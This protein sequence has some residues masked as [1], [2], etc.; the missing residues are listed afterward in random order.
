M[1]L[2]RGD[3]VYYRGEVWTV[4]NEWKAPG[5]AQ[6]LFIQRIHANGKS[7]WAGVGAEVVQKVEQVR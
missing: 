5:E 4:L 3:M 2:Q 6:H 1:E 7:G